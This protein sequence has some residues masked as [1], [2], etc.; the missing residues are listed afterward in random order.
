MEASFLGELGKKL[1]E[2]WLSLLV[3]PGLLYVGPA[4]VAS[5]LGHT[6]W[7]DLPALITWLDRQTAGRV[8]HSGAAVALLAVA[9]LLGSAGA[10]LAA[11]ALGGCV[12]RLWLG[13]WPASLRPLT[14]LLEQHRTRRWNH[15]HQRLADTVIERRRAGVPLDPADPVLR[16]LAQRRNRIALAPP[17]RPTWIGD[18]IAAVDTRVWHAYGLDL[19]A[20][21]PRLWLIIPD[22]AREEV[23]ASRLAF[24]T[25]ATLTAW[26]LLYLPL[27]LRWWPALLITAVACLTG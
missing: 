20:C 9:V 19:T 21:W 22:T 13:T 6:R 16:E 11:Q 23:R 26:G 18:R 17:R 15:A 3:L 27:G 10:G 8:A 7:H 12:Q 4:T 1:A 24:D 5:V 14:R 25:A 2:K